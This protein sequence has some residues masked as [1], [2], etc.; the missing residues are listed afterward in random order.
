MIRSADWT[1]LNFSLLWVGIMNSDE[2][3]DLIIGAAD[4]SDLS[5]DV[6][7]FLS[8]GLDERATKALC[9]NAASFPRYMKSRVTP[10]LSQ[11]KTASS[12]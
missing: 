9:V 1:F 7:W 11:N 12:G 6:L 2:R 4:Y 3:I 8:K 5:F 10:N